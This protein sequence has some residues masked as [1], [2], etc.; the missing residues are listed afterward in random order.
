MPLGPEA[1]V[2]ENFRSA[3]DTSIGEMGGTSLNAERMW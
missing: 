2:L 1:D 3:E